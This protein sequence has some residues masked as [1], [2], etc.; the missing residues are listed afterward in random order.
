VVAGFLD[1]HSEL[2]VDLR[3]ND[4]NLD[5]I[6]EGLDVAVRIGPLADSSLLVR[7]VGEVRRL[8]VASPD[9]LA[10][11]G[12]PARP[13]ELPDHQVVLILT[14]P[15][16]EDWRF[17]RRDGREEI[18]RLAPR[19]TISDIDAGLSA[20]RAGHGITRALSYQVAED[21]AAGR[22]VRLLPEYE[23][24]ALPVQ[25]V[26]SGARLM[27]GKVRAFLDHAAAELG[28]LPVLRPDVR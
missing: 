10:R 26:T 13:G 2:G 1:L 17:R 5:L 21:L 8:T 11:R 16:L 9:Y 25:L 7:K 28:R 27:P 22:L 20:V 14:R 12:T 3:L 19:L 23:P 6:E 15:E 4:R 24:Q 18:V